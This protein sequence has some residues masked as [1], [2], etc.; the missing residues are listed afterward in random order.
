MGVKT[1]NLKA[2][3]TYLY[4]IRDLLEVVAEWDSFLREHMPPNAHWFPRIEAPFGMQRLSTDPPGK[5]RREGLNDGLKILFEQAGLT[6]MTAH[7]F[8]HGH[9][10]FGLKRARDIG[11]LKAVSMNL[12]H[13]S[14]SVTDGVYAIFSDNDLGERLAKLSQDSG[15][16]NERAEDA[17]RTLQEEIKRLQQKNRSNGASSGP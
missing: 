10:L 11:D 6:P 5:S 8:R 3:V 15:E 14:L 12:M 4:H 16:D 1:K 2:A 9:A 7:S 17:L 13:E